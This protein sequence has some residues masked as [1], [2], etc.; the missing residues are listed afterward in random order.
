[1]ADR[2]HGIPAPSTT[3]TVH[4]ADWDGRDLS[5]EC[6]TFGLFEVDGGD[7]SFTGLPGADLRRSVFRGVRMREADLTGTRF[8]DARVLRCDLSGAWLHQASFS[9]CDLRG[10]EL[11]SFDPATVGLKGASSTRRRPS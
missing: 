8:D 1:V 7:W 5:R 2:K 6:H 9:G 10:S 3:S 11:S 4:S